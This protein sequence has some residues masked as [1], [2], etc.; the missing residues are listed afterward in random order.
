M[1]GIAA[2]SEAGL[3]R[4][5]FLVDGVVKEEYFP[6]TSGLQN[7]EIAFPWFGIQS[8][9]H[10]LGAIAYDLNGRLA[11]VSFLVCRLV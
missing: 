7:L 5:D 6:S 8:G 11:Q 9:W 3:V 10:Q 2:Q 4:I 1:V